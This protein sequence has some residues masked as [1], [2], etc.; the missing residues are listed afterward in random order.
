MT[1]DQKKEAMSKELLRILAYGHGFKVLEPGPDHGVDMIVSP[2]T[3]RIEPTGKT[4][5][6]DS[7]F[8]LEMQLKATT[9]KSII[10]AGDNIK[11]DL[12]VKN[13]NDLIQRRND[14]LPLHLIVVVLGA[15]PPACFG[16]DEGS[17]RLNA[18]AYWYLPPED[19]VPTSNEATI[20]IAIPKAQIIT[21][22]FFCTRY[23]QLGIDL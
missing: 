22:D 2:V 8:K 11:F 5:Y 15:P 18:H 19:A 17:L 4:R 3:T 6:L 7:P 21:A 12:E 13:Y 23:K 14:L 1:E 9:V 16:M 10:D 20:R